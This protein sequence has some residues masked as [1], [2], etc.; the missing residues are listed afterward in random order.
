[1]DTGDTDGTTE[2]GTRRPPLSL[3]A[4]VIVG[5]VTTAVALGSVGWLALR[6][7]DEEFGCPTEEWVQA[8][9]QEVQGFLPADASITGSA[10]SDCDDRRGLTL[11]VD[12][13]DGN[14]AGASLRAAAVAAGW[15]P[16]GRGI[17][18]EGVFQELGATI[19][20]WKHEGRRLEVYA[21]RG[22]CF[23]R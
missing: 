7:L 2:P 3:R 5:A 10:V 1:M 16:D 20:I 9:S 15:S 4:K 18:V 13:P 11:Y 21:S 6:Q 17:C 14:A 8:L 19:S 22:E 12:A 23:R